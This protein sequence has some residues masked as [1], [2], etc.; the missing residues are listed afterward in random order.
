[1]LNLKVKSSI[2]G[3]QIPTL[4]TT[5]HTHV[6]Q[7]FSNFQEMSCVIRLPSFSVYAALPHVTKTCRQWSLLQW[8]AAV[9][10]KKQ[11]KKTHTSRRCQSQSQEGQIRSKQWRSKLPSAHWRA[12]GFKQ[13]QPACCTLISNQTQQIHHPSIQTYWRLSNSWHVCQVTRALWSTSLFVVC[14][15]YVSQFSSGTVIQCQQ[16]H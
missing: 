4:R 10:K 13:G 8:Q 6:I 7:P 3:C 15:V 16:W 5:N 14:S 12:A 2:K 1:M 11:N 9:S